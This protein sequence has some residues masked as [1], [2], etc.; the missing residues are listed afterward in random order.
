MSIDI[1]NLRNEADKAR[2]E[3]ELLASLRKQAKLAE[4]YNQALV[5]QFT[6]KQLNITP[7]APRRRS[8]QEER[9]DVVFQ[10]QTFFNNMKTIMNPD[11]AQRLM[12]ELTDMDIYLVNSNFK[13]ILTELKG[14]TNIDS[15]FFRTFLQQYDR[16]LATTRTAG[17]G[18]ETG[19]TIPL[20]AEALEAQL[21]TLSTVLETQI[22]TKLGNQFNRIRTEFDALRPFITG[23]NDTLNTRFTET[24]TEAL[25]TGNA[26]LATR[27]MELMDRLRR[28]GPS[29]E[30]QARILE[31]LNRL[32]LQVGS[33]GERLDQGEDIPP[34]EILE[35][36][37]MTRLQ[38]LARKNGLAGARV[39]ADLIANLL[40]ERQQRIDRGQQTQGFERGEE[41]EPMG[42]APETGK[43]R[44]RV[45]RGYRL[46]DADRGIYNDIYIRPNDS[47]IQLIERNP[48]YNDLAKRYF[49]DENWQSQSKEA[50][51][52][53]LLES[54]KDRTID[55]REILAIPT[56]ID[57][58]RAGEP[59]QTGEES[60]GLKLE[61]FRRLVYEKTLAMFIA[62]QVERARAER[63]A[64]QAAGATRVQTAFRGMMGRRRAGEARTA[65]E[66]RAIAERLARLNVEVQ[67]FLYGFDELTPA[68]VLIRH[69][70]GIDDLPDGP[71][72]PDGITKADLR[73]L[74]QQYYDAMTAFPFARRG[75]D[76][77]IAPQRQVAEQQAFQAKQQMENA[78]NRIRA[79][80]G[81]AAP[82]DV[83]ALR[84]EGAQVN[85]E[86][87]RVQDAAAQANADRAAGRINARAFID[88]RTQLDQDLVRFTTRR[89]EI[90]RELQRGGEPPL[91]GYGMSM[92]SYGNTKIMKTHGRRLVGRGI[93][94]DEQERYKEFGKYLIHMPSLKKGILNLKFPSFAS[95][96]TIKQTILSA[97]LLDLITD[98]LENK[99]INKRLYSRMSKEDQD[100]IYTIAQKAE[101]DETL[102]MGIRV[103]DTHKK[104]MERFQLVRGQVMAGNNNPE[105]L[106]ELK[107]Y[108]MK[109]MRDGTMNKHQGSDLLFEIS[110]LT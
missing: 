33:I 2:K 57:R 69:R 85:A 44:I 12:T 103:N 81:G 21:D 109:F 45:P 13:D 82:I 94:S 10:R 55:N 84:A 106:R 110:C 68:G 107:Q 52:V 73:A 75:E 87:R 35:T 88:L 34:Q 105:I 50:I 90:N 71:L 7:V 15:R 63:L 62:R 54:V 79:A 104:E 64:R 48:R 14:R 89:D 47:L 43:V 8:V 49:G 96:P 65:A 42:E 72:A 92:Q 93:S 80:A 40:M 17:P 26:R 39:K 30:N 102:G 23:L 32:R 37:P 46:A 95:I 100:F 6:N 97:D 16:K 18:T 27:I 76:P 67:E 78:M 99:T 11:E 36:Y 38:A 41:E 61:E 28:E 83:A 74:V 98:L 9:D 56:D 51:A 24:L 66:D 77:A 4:D 91:A 31:A 19:I 5:E 25:R 59:T 3:N 53:F 101:I 29:D 58:A 1:R 108:I 22:G 70:D 86:L 60:R 20:T